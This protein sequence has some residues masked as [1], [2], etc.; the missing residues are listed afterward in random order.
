MGIWQRLRGEH[1]QESGSYTDALVQLIQSRAGGSSAL[2]GTTAALECASGFVQRAFASAEVSTGNSIKAAALD[3]HTLGM[4]GRAMIRTGEYLAVIEI[5]MEGDALRLAPASSWDVQGG[6]DPESWV[7]RVS[8]AGPGR[9]SAFENIPAAGVVNIRYTSE[10]TRP[11]RGVGTFAE[12]FSLGAFIR[13][14][15]S[16]SGGRIQWATRPAPTPCECW[17]RIRTNIGFEGGSPGP[18]GPFSFCRKSVRF[19]GTGPQNNASSGWDS[20]RI[21]AKVPD[22]SIKAASI[23]FGEVL[24]ACGLSVALSTIVKERPNGKHTDRRS[25][26]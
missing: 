4:I 20:K 11:W 26:R 21:G 6:A 10:T 14:S 13:R 22:S 25:M 2:P 7:Y 19:V 1:R 9:Q 24:A 3:P 17:G 8:L 15:Q 18:S 16:G 5:G 23:A 12:C